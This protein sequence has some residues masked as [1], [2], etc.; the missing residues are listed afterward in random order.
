MKHADDI[1]LN[2]KKCLLNCIR[3]IHDHHGGFVPAV[4]TLEPF[5]HTGSGHS[6][7]NWLYSSVLEALQSHLITANPFSSQGRE[8]VQ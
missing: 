3:S 2:E 8:N 4:C 6:L 7:M 5:S 1:F